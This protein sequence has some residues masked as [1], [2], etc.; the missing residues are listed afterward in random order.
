MPLARTE[1][2][3]CLE[4]HGFHVV[5]L[6]LGQGLT[7]V[8][9][10]A[11]GRIFGPYLDDLD[12]LGWTPALTE[13]DAALGSGQWNIGGE[14]IWLAPERMFN[15]TDPQA[16]L[17]TYR[18]DPALDPGTWQL[19]AEA[20]GMV[21]SARMIV[22]RTDGGA[23]MDLMISRRVVPL[24]VS[25]A[26]GIG[27]IRGGYRQSITVEGDP[28]GPPV[29][30]WLIRQVPLGGQA[31][32]SAKGSGAG[33]CVFGDPPPEALSP[34]DGQW[35]V[36]FGPRGFFKTTYAR[37][38]LGHGGLSYAMAGS[39]M[40]SVLEFRPSLAAPRDY[41]ETLPRD[42]GG[43]GQAAALFRDDG[44]FGTYG[45]LEMYG[46]RSGPAEGRLAVDAQVLHGETAA[47]C[48]MG[49]VQASDISSIPIS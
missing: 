29:V 44:R 19:Q 32:L 17:E 10:T 22:N 15:F 7:L 38:S 34:M 13:F 18:V 5:L 39:S 3:G 47:V 40:A 6:D 1:L 45:E 12:I 23:D 11:G 28:E 31:R 20:D 42:P 48:G 37:Q 4:D 9:T 41:P 35:C 24:A 21:L 25:G 8:A 14:R 43:P 2:I 46:H 33:Q 16:M 26:S 30:P 36:P 27:P 49:T